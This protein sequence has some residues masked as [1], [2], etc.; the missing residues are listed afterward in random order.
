MNNCP[1]TNAETSRQKNIPKGTMPESSPPNRSPD[2]VAQGTHDS[3][4]DVVSEIVAETERR[5][6]SGLYPPDLLARLDS[7]FD[8][9][10]PISFRRTGIDGAIRA[11]ESAAFVNVDP[12][13]TSTRRTARALKVS[14]KKLT[15]WYHLHVARQITTLG[16]QI[17]RPLQMLHEAIR[18]L[19]DR[20][21][22]LE[23]AI[24]LP[25]SDLA[26]QVQTLTSRVIPIEVVREVAALF[27]GRTGRVVHLG[28][29]KNSLLEL[30]VSSGVDA[31]GV[32]PQGGGGL[33][34]EIRAEDP[35]QHLRVLAPD[36]LG[37][38]VVSGI[39]ETASTPE[40]VELCRLLA[41]RVAAGGPIVLVS[42]D[43]STWI[44]EVGHVAADLVV[45]GPLHPETWIHLLTVAGT[46]APRSESTADGYNL[47]VASAL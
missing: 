33:E 23:H 40:R 45:A 24:E 8:R 7:E 44:S 20:V 37:G 42:A 36:S 32:A 3:F 29:N 1:A 9:F 39:T 27:D 18:S 5:R 22:K 46:R 14:V 19:T 4:D 43:P 47:I 11:V 26:E 28:A 25:T 30:L 17:T 31:Y 35:T 10:A 34:I 15:G 6:A 38:A 16:I 41:G 21:A 12:P 13:V 2:N